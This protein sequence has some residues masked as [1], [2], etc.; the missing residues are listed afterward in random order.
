M[1]NLLSNKNLEFT[2]VK[3]EQLY[4]NV[5]DWGCGF[6]RATELLLKQDTKPKSY[7]GIEIDKER[8][9][10]CM[11]TFSK[12]KNCK[13]LWI[14]KNDYI[15]HPTFGIKNPTYSIPVSGK[16]ISL[17]LAY[18]VFTHLYYDQMQF[19]LKE[20][21]KLLKD[22]GIAVTTWFLI[23]RNIFPILSE[24]QYCIYVNEFNS[25]QA[26][27]VDFEQVKKMIDDAGL[28]IIK[29]RMPGVMGHQAELFLAKKGVFK[30]E[31]IGIFKNIIGY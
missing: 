14:P 18:S 5:L 22:D 30:K 6:G 19:F 17:F 20:I 8:Y 12:E 21:F 7:I 2:N 1:K 9:N 3:E 29:M 15:K 16:S 11:K 13:F 26:I 27:Y 28:E 25:T 4:S 10:H 24:M 31:E 23:N